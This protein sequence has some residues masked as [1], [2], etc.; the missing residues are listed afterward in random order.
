MNET[1][2]CGKIVSSNP[3]FKPRWCFVKFPRSWSTSRVLDVQN[4]SVDYHKHVYYSFI[5]N[6]Y[7]QRLLLD[8]IKS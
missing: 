8:I 5:G 4:Y 1:Q 7:T 2:N 3:E 6:D